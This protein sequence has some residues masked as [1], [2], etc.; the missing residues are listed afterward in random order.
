M[1]L[2][3]IDGGPH[4]RRNMWFNSMLREEPYPGLNCTGRSPRWYFPSGPERRC[5]TVVVRPCRQVGLGTRWTLA[6]EGAREVGMRSKQHGPYVRGYT[7][8]T[9]GGTE[10]RDNAS[11]PQSLKPPSVRTG[12]C[13][14]TPRSLIR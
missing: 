1:K 5:C 10:S 3:G 6:P 7:R 14:P 8:V 12:V 2:K 4:K 11:C 9:M 13:N